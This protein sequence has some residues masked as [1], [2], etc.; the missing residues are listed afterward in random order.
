MLIALITAMLL[1]GGLEPLFGKETRVAVKETIT[2]TQR[3]KEVLGSLKEI[4]SSRKKPSKSGGA[5][6]KDLARLEA[7]RSA[8]AADIRAIYDEILGFRGESHQAL[9]DGIFSMREIMTE[10][11]WQAVFGP[12]S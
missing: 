6:R 9:I 7:D 4:E 10:E 12:D 1:G 8:D 3:Q 11:E 2:D 5:A